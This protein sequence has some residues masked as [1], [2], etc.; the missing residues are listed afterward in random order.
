[1]IIGECWV[2]YR[3][4]GCCMF[5]GLV[6]AYLFLGGAGGGLLFVASALGMSCPA[7]ELVPGKGRGN[8]RG[9]IDAPVCWRKLLVGAFLASA[10]SLGVGLLCLLGDL[11]RVERAFSVLVSGKLSFANI[12][13]YA[14]CLGVM[15]ALVQTWAWAD[16]RR[17]FCLGTVRAMQGVGV[18]A[19]FVIML[20]TGLLLGDMNGVPLWR[21]PLLPALFVLSS[22]S[23]GCVLMLLLMQALRVGPDFAREAH[24]IV[25]CDVTLVVAEGIAVALYLA[26]ACM[27]EQG[28]SSAASAAHQ[29]LVGE[30]AATFWGGFIAVGLVAPLCFEAASLHGDGAFCSCGSTAQLRAVA[31]CGCVLIGAALLRYLIVMAGTHPFLGVGTGLGFPGAF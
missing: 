10:V 11:G 21:S 18:V 6:I 2:A 3:R 22:A 7:A 29:L 13:T 28:A 12:G 16:R 14:L 25:C 24:M 26:G 9:G 30:H 8:V 20:Y 15:L 5:S 23:C 31:S 4:W 27:G 19:G 1:M 17:L